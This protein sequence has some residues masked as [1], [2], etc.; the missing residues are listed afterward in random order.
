[1][2][3]PDCF[4]RY[5]IS[6]GTRNFTS[7]KSDVGPIR[8]GRCSDAWFYNGFIHWASEPSKH[9][10][11]RHMRST[12]CPSSLIF[13]WLIESYIAVKSAASSEVVR[14]K[15]SYSAHIQQDCR[16]C[17]SPQPPSRRGHFH[18]TLLTGRMMD[19]FADGAV[20]TW[21]LIDRRAGHRIMPSQVGLSVFT[22]VVEKATCLLQR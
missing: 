8:I 5:R 1:M 14:W 11:R 3:E 16:Y 10:C 22:A 12:E 15:A 6:A 2:P 9:L 13:N 7:G 18:E 19:A 17:L 21:P 20:Y 4:L